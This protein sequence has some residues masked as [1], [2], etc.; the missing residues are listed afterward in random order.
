MTKQELD[1]FKLINF[2]PLELIDHLKKFQHLSYYTNY[3]A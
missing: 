1:M 2:K 3:E